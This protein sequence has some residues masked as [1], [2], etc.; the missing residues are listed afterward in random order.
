ME[1][2]AIAAQV[3]KLST[4]DL[5]EIARNSVL[6]SGLSHQVRCGRPS[7][8]LGLSTRAQGVPVGLALSRLWGGEE[9]DKQGPCHTETHVLG[10]STEE[11]CEF[12]WLLCPF[13]DLYSNV[14]SSEAISNHR[15]TIDTFA[16]ILHPF[17]LLFFILFIIIYLVICN[18]VFFCLSRMEFPVG[19]RLFCSASYP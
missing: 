1:E 5:C 4:C 19:W 11:A 15:S 16:I 7:V 18:Y 2:Y 3:W 17:N 12:S 8:S 6:Q 10:K 14:S 13:S 9:G